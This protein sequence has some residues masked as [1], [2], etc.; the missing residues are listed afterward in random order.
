MPTIT[1]KLNGTDTNPYHK[2]G[3]RMN[4]FPSQYETSDGLRFLAAT[5]ISK[6]D[7]EG[8][9]RRALTGFSSEFINLCVKLYKPN[10]MVSFQVE[11]NVHE[12]P[13]THAQS[14]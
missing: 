2:L 8:H 9:I 3:L 12:H 10:E 4:P 7:P 5:P 14:R 13:H 1:V 11:W 6:E